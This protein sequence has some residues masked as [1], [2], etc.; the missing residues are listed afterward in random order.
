LGDIETG[1]WYQLVDRPRWR[2]QISLLVRWPTGFTDSPNNF[3]DLSTG[4]GQMDVELGFRNDLVLSEQLWLHVGGRYGA[5]LPAELDRRVAPVNILL[6]PVTSLARVRRDLGDYLALDVAP[7]WRLDD[8]FA[9][10]IGYHFYRRGATRHSY[11][12]PADDQRVGVP[13]SV[14]DVETEVTR[15][16][17]GAGLTFSTIARHA[18][19]RARLPYTVSASFQRTFFGEGGQVPVAETFNLT[20]RAYIRLWG[21]IGD[22]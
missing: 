19:G 5:Q 11:V 12:N 6:A 21:V 13:A 20:V 3:I 18:R 10:G 17:I 2:S 4:D 1:A 22:R 9:L 15:M 14:L 8:A 7:S 16:R